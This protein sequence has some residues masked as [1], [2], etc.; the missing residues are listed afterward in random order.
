MQELREI[1]SKQ[2]ESS[3]LESGNKGEN[4][5]EKQTN[6]EIEEKKED[7]NKKWNSRFEKLAYFIEHDELEKVNTNFEGMN[8]FIET[9]EFAEAI[10][11][12][13]KSIFVLEHIH[14]KYAFSLE[15]IF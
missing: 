7:T 11:E 6:Q 5:E 13:D 12:L 1:L 9:K 10:N 15:N 8:S 14:H 3:D 2:L 4:E